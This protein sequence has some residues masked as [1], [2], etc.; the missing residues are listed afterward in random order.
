MSN[1]RFPFRFGTYSCQILIDGR[2]IRPISSLTSSVNPQALAEELRLHGYSPTEVIS[3]F[4]I[5]FLDT[6]RNLVLV[7]T[8]WGCCTQKMQGRLVSN[9]Q[10]AGFKP[11]DIDLVVLTHGDRDHLGGLIDAR[12]EP[13]FPYASYLISQA[14]W[15]WYDDQANLSRMP[16]DIVNFYH[17]VLPVIKDH[18]RLVAEETE[19]LPGLSLI[20]AP[21]HRPGH[22]VI[23]LTLGG[24][25]LLH[26]AD[27][28]AHPILMLH[29]EWRWP[30]DTAPDQAAETRRQLLNWAAENKAM[31]F[32]SH[33]PF[34][35]LGTLKPYASGWEWQ[36]VDL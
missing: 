31:C 2:E 7:D 19:F 18:L 24:K 26:L 29:P 12:G 10:E 32:G 27:A 28:V 33:L 21:G 36:A 17:Q 3:D 5:L 16:A 9:L 13:A 11:E 14:A 20:P 15:E 34:P 8:G 25:H 4:N 30:F 35:G 6:G 1:E 22:S 23:R